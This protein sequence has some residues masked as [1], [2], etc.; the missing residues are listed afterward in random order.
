MNRSVSQYGGATTRELEPCGSA[1]VFP[2]ITV[3]VMNHGRD[4]MHLQRRYEF[5]EKRIT[6][7]MNIR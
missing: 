2:I 3:S 1:P 5:V 7:T 6:R 4:T